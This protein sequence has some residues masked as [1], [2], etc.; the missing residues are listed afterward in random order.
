MWNWKQRKQEGIFFCGTFT[1]C[2]FVIGLFKLDLSPPFDI[3]PIAFFF[4]SF[5]SFFLANMDN[6]VSP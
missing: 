5:F 6:K 3:S 2:V 1:N 4:Y